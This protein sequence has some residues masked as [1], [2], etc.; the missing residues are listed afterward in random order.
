M[1][2]RELYGV[3]QVAMG[4]ESLHLCAFDIRGVQ[5]GSF[6]LCMGDPR[7][8]LSQFGFREND[9]LEYIYDMSDRWERE[10]R[11]KRFGIAEPNKSYPVCT[12]SSGACPPKECG[13]PLDSH[14]T[15]E[16]ASPHR[17]QTV[18]ETGGL[19]CR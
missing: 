14:R 12:G 9:K 17:G 8:P 1:T 11:I 19:I 2:L 4:W 6:E 3:L 15:F 7:T 18:L 10:I 5:Y 13:G 16:T